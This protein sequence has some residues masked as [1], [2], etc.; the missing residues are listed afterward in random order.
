M[1]IKWI[2]TDMDG[3][4]L[5][6]ND[7]IPAQERE[8]LIACQQRGVKVILAS[9]RSY[10]RLMPYAEQLRLKEYGGALI[11]VN[12]MAVNELQTGRRQIFK[13]L[14]P[15]E[16]DELFVWF[17]ER[18]LEVQ[19]FEDRALYYWF[20]PEIKKLK[21]AERQ[22]RSLPE[23]YPW[24]GG[25]WSW[26]SDSRDGYPRQR[27]VDG[28]EEMP[29][30]LNKINVVA[31]P[32]CIRRVYQEAVAHFGERYEFFRTCPRLIEV[33]PQGI[34]KGQALKRYMKEMGIAADE[35]LVFGDGEND[36]DT[37]SQV[38]YSVAMGN[39]ED[40]IKEQAHE[41]TTGNREDGVAAAL[42]KYFP[43]LK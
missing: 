4:L 16:R 20:P 31:E 12:G 35:V 9:G 24:T 33:A 22:A 5:N 3:T 11:E 34:T 41:V 23:D 42:E 17:Q 28:P 27:W 29:E 43:W 19:G 32:E 37:F 25:A 7:E 21:E 30:A 10:T 18:G 6:E 36:L 15:A 26:L 14:G 13:R 39:A 40:F 8:Y 2:V 38:K 1:D